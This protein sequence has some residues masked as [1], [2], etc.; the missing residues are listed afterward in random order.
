MFLE[1]DEMK[2]AILYTL[3]KNNEPISMEIL[4]KVLTWEKEV[5]NY[6]DLAIMLNELI[7]D[8]YVSRTFYR[9]EESFALTQKGADTNEFFFERV[10][11]SIRRRIDDIIG[12][13]KFDEQTDPNACTTE[14]VPIASNR[15][16]ATLKMLDGG[17]ELFRLGIDLGSYNEASRGA[18]KLQEKAEEIYRT[19]LKMLDYNEEN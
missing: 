7:D 18:K 3:K 13:M 4:C 12:R 2:F 11:L 19:V 1:H 17:S 8:K 5:M 16:M 10:P 15:H 14:V 6:F 9:N